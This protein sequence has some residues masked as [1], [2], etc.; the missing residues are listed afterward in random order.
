MSPVSPVAEFMLFMIDSVHAPLM[1]FL[2]F[3]FTGTYERAMYD[4]RMRYKAARSFGRD[5]E[6]IVKQYS[7]DSVCA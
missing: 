2:D 6:P 1:D 3:Q 5:M 7:H 4:G